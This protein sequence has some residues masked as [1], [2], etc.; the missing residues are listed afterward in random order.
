MVPVAGFSAVKRE[1]GRDRIV[2]RFSG[3][4]LSHRPIAAGRARRNRP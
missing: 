3:D 4:I 1:S 2:F